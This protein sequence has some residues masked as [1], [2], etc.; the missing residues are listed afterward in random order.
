MCKQEKIMDLHQKPI[1]NSMASW[2]NP[3]NVIEFW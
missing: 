1:D 3:Q 2:F